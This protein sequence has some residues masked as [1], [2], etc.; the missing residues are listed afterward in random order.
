MMPDRGIEIPPMCRA[1]ADAGQGRYAQ[2][3]FR[4]IDVDR[5]FA[6]S[7]ADQLGMYQSV[8]LLGPRYVGK[9]FLVARVEELLAEE[10]TE[11][12]LSMRLLDKPWA[13]ES[14]FW[15]AAADAVSGALEDLPW[16]PP[17]DP[18]RLLDA[19]GTFLKIHR[20]QVVGLFADVDG[21]PDHIA[22]RLL[23]GIRT[24][25]T[26]SQDSP[27]HMAVLLTGSGGLAPLVHGP[28]SEFDCAV[29]YVIQGFERNMF[30]EWV[31]ASLA[32]FGWE[33]ESPDECH[34]LL[35]GSCGGNVYMLRVLFTAIAEGR[36]IHGTP[37]TDPIAP[38]EIEGAMVH[39]YAPVC[40]PYDFLVHAFARI[41]NSGQ[42]C[43]KL[44][45]LLEHGET[46]VPQA[47]LPSE[48]GAPS[49]LELCGLAVRDGGRLVPARGVVHGIVK[50]YFTA[51]RM[52]DLFACNQRWDLAFKW[53]GEAAASDGYWIYPPAVRL[54]LPLAVQALQ[55]ALHGMAP[56]G[57][58]KLIEF[59]AKGARYV[60][61]FEEVTVWRQRA[62]EGRWS[63]AWDE[64]GTGDAELTD[65]CA[66]LPAP[67][68]LLEGRVQIDEKLAPH[69]MIVGLPK[70][71][72]E[73]GSA[74]VM[75][76]FATGTPLTRE[77]VDLCRGVIVSLV[78]AYDQAETIDDAYRQQGIQD[79]LL[80][81]IPDILRAATSEA[82][83]VRTALRTAAEK[84]RQIGFRRV[85]FS[86]VNAERTHIEGVFDSR[87]R[88]EPEI[89]K[90]SVWGI[91]DQDNVIDVQQLC[92]GKKEPVRVDDAMTHPL[93]DRTA[94]KKAAMGAIVLVPIMLDGEVLGTLHVERNDKAL[95]SPED[96][97]ALEYCAD[98]LAVVIDLVEKKNILET[99]VH[100]N[101]EPVFVADGCGRLRF[102]NQAGAR[103]TGLREGWPSRSPGTNIDSC[104]MLKSRD[105]LRRAMGT[106]RAVWYRVKEIEKRWQLYAAPIKDWRRRCFGAVLQATDLT[107]E[108][109]L[110]HTITR[111]AAA[112]S[113]AALLSAIVSA[114]YERGHEW[115][116]LYLIDDETGEL[117][118]R[119]QR[120]A[121]A[122][123]ETEQSF[124]KGKVIL[125]G[126][127][128]RGSESWICLDESK[129]VVF[130][131]DPD[132]K[133]GTV[134]TTDSGL[135]VRSI[136]ICL[137]PDP[138]RKE[139]GDVWI[140][141]PLFCRDSR[142]P[143]GKLSLKCPEDFTPEQFELLHILAEVSSAMLAAST[144]QREEMLRKGIHECKVAMEKAVGTTAHHLLARL[145]AL[146]VLRERFLS[147]RGDEERL[148]ELDA[149]FD[150]LLERLDNELANIQQRLRPVDVHAD[151]A[152]I[153]DL[154]RT[155]LREFLADSSFTLSPSSAVDADVDA[156]VLGTALD[157]LIMNAGRAAGGIERLRIEAS[158]RSTGQ[159]ITPWCVIDLSD[160]GPGI[161]ADMRDRVFEELYSAWPVGGRGTGLGLGY[162]R[163]VIE[164]HGGSIRIAE[165]VKTGARFV[166]RLPRFASAQNGPSAGQ[167]RAQTCSDLALPEER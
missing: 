85:M 33:L 144:V 100:A 105:A 156:P 40:R 8:V 161:P 37:G 134:S 158:V 65:I 101:H 112:S 102:V 120:G 35:F 24:L 72:D 55:T 49:E 2:N 46:P 5:D 117:V 167:R 166:I 80:K 73:I 93:T 17:S 61:G 77:R 10:G 76:N 99:A 31:D 108:N 38:A 109:Q 43:E 127:D 147:A 19:L 92:V 81:S 91:T 86:L 88:G 103:Q 163:R 71:G 69:A 36:R 157:E 25:A 11:R 96:V 106:E 89:A 131:Y 142:K 13:S 75:S 155:R 159:D 137:C 138:C 15:Q 132:K 113:M 16:V 34:G 57:V 90:E 23:K 107:S 118:G 7:L 123:S 164:A 14:E 126:R 26:L 74:V 153:T 129:P 12:V 94:V 133:E 165:P 18:K 124:A 3:P 145:A 79:H 139:A 87:P 98:Q 84:I 149:Q 151:R 51:W 121:E 78:W 39:L 130:E 42:S 136:H 128:I 135:E 45:D 140:D 141:F 58:R 50:D 47:T 67:E 114:T 63:C 146:G 1:S 62:G 20:C 22:R 111:L 64:G 154:L 6:K 97:R 21:L 148:T 4:Y 152:D 115:V 53:Y 104:L 95:P 28:D 52:G 119:M 29:Q 82:A 44:A 32:G 70:R 150:D 110:L 162:V 122:G 83:G 30:D 68:N 66:L 143:L 48:V 125:P 60:L 56:E 54:Q 59:F 41:E 27:G 116:R 160:N 9:R